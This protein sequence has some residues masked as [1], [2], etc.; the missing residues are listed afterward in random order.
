MQK[1]LRNQFNDYF[2]EEKYE[3]YKKEIDA[4]ILGLTDNAPSNLE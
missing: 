2:T 3:A 1:D 4:L